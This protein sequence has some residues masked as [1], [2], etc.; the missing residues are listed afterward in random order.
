MEYGILPAALL[1]YDT[2]EF[3]II[4]IPRR[5]RLSGEPLDTT[6]CCVL[7]VTGTTLAEGSKR[8][9]RWEFGYLDR[10]WRQ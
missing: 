9:G 7:K 3:T 2:S 10:D 8:R 5:A 6:E 1:M 4:I